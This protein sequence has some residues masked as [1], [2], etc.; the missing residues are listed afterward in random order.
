M[1]QRVVRDE[2]GER[3]RDPVQ[4]SVEALLGEHVVE[5]VRQAAIGLDARGPL[6]RVGVRV[7]LEQAQWE[8]VIAHGQSSIRLYSRS[9]APFSEPTQSKAGAETGS[10]S[11]C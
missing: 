10:V 8:C 6:G 2:L 3:V 11:P 4:Q 5:D 1:V 9:G 7:L